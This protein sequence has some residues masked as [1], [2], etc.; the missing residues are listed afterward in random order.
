ME[1]YQARTAEQ[2]KEVEIP[3]AKRSVSIP[4]PGA[5]EWSMQRVDSLERYK[6]Q[7]HTKLSSGIERHYSN[8][9]EGLAHSLM[10]TA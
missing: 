7:T 5:R 2:A 6:T 4:F 9:K 10:S 3:I 8:E 1:E